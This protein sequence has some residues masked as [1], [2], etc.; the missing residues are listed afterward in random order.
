VDD[1]DREVPGTEGTQEMKEFTKKLRRMIMIPSD[2]VGIGDAV[3]EVD[4]DAKG[5]GLR[6]FRGKRWSRRFLSWWSLVGFAIVAAQM[7]EK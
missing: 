1:V 6:R 3:W 4:M 7:G 5:I 2:D